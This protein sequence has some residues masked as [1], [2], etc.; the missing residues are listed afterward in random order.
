MKKKRRIS[1]ILLNGLILLPLALPAGCGNSGGLWFVEDWVRDVFFGGVLTVAGDIAVAL[2]T[3]PIVGADGPQGPTGPTGPEGPVGPTGPA[4][5][6]ASTLFDIQIDDFFANIGNGGAGF[7]ITAVTISEPRLGR[8][9][10]LPDSF[11]FR[12]LIPQSYQGTNP[13]VMRVALSRSGPASSGG[14]FAFQVTGRRLQNGSATVDNYI[15]PPVTTVVPNGP[16]TGTEFI[17]LDLP[18]NVAVPNGLGGGTLS[19]GDLLAMEL[20]TT[21]VDGGDYEVLSVEF[22]ETTGSPTASGATIS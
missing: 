12:I 2:L 15:N 19:A 1:R 9:L 8:L 4:G 14:P 7:P 17:L 20:G 18:L 11:A 16:F 3:G 22:I 13:I 10:T 6:D 5:A 21:V